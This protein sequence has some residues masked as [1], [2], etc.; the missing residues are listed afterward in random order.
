[1]SNPSR[2]IMTMA[3]VALSLAVSVSQPLAASNAVPEAQPLADQPPPP[4]PEGRLLDISSGGNFYGFLV[5]D[6]VSRHG[7]AVDAW[8]YLVIAPPMPFG[9]SMGV[10]G[11]D[12]LSFD[13]SKRVRA[14]LAAWYFDEDGQVLTSDGPS[15]PEA[16]G[17]GASQDMLSRVVCDG[18]KVGPGN[19]VIGHRAA[20]RAVRK[21]LAP[22]N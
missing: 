2:T 1:M 17:S 20:I 15:A 5:E 4:L 10:Q 3:A 7:S 13:C 19:E 14:H 22:G 18:A 12:H 9:S 16:F 21:M 8:F 6:Q 11:L